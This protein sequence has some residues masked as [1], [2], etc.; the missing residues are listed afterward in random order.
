MHSAESASAENN[1]MGY[2]TGIGVYWPG[3]VSEGSIEAYSGDDV[4]DLSCYLDGLRD[5]EDDAGEYTGWLTRI[6]Q[7]ES[8][9]VC[10]GHVEAEREKRER[11][12][13]LAPYADALRGRGAAFDGGSAESRLDIAEAWA[14]EFEDVADAEA[15]MDAGVWDADTASEL[16]GAGVTPADLD[17]A[18]GRVSDDIRERVEG[19]GVVYAL[20]NGDLL[21]S[22]LL[23]DL[24]RDDA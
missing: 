23:A 16:R 5:G 11:A 2:T 6:V 14:K 17:D 18:D 20:C 9:R 3:E 21:L 13:R 24:A 7:G 1:R 15:Y 19:L 8:V 10:G 22:R 4:G 12:E